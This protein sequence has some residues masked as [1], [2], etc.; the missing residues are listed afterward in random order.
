MKRIALIL[1]CLLF[2]FICA[3][4]MALADVSSKMP[5][6]VSI[7]VEDTEEPQKMAVILQIVLM[8]TILSVAPALLMMLTSFTR[9]V[10]ILSFLKRAMST[11]SQPSAQ[12]LVGLALFLTFYIMAPVFSEINDTAL[13]PFLDNKISGK[14]AIENA[15]IPLRKFMFH[16]TRE[17]DLAL[18]VHL[19]K[20][21]RPKNK[22]EVPIHLLIPA[23][24][25]SELKTAFQMGFVLF[26]PFLVLDMVVASVLLSMGM[27][28]LPPIMVSMPF[29]ILLFVLVDGWHLIIRSITMSYQY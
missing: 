26:L 21:K 23:F 28:M 18:F 24:I 5:M 6:K 11:G 8:L 29:K 13:T 9:I 12:I 22:E 1:S 4:R 17:K 16:Y 3:E 27:M 19:S 20:M 14:V 10:I 15:E 2:C 25:M 7:S